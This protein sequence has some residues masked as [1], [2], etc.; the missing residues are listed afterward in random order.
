MNVPSRAPATKTVE[1]ATAAMANVRILRPRVIAADRRSAPRA[2]VRSVA[3]TAG[4]MNQRATRMTAIGRTSQPRSTAANRIAL[5]RRIPVRHR[6][7]IGRRSSS[8]PT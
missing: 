8:T 4:A 2:V 5:G 6:R 1:I 3:A 7:R